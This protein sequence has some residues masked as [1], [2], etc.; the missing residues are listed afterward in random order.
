MQFS[1][2]K[3]LYF[4]GSNSGKTEQGEYYRVTFAD[5]EGRT[6]S[7]YTEAVT[8]GRAQELK[9][10]AEVQPVI[11][12]YGRSNGGVGARL[13]DFIAASRG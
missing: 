10:F 7:L 9:Q 2:D 13:S 1:S 12:L 5:G 3:A 6:I 4:I 8:F 11:D